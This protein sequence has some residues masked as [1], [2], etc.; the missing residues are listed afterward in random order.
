MMFAAGM[1]VMMYSCIMSFGQTGKDLAEAEQVMARRE[2]ARQEAALRKAMEPQLAESNRLAEIAAEREKAAEVLAK[3]KAEAEAAK[4]ELRDRSQVNAI[5]FLKK[6]VAEGSIS[7]TYK[8]GLR[9]LEGDGVEIDK[10][11][12]IRLLKLAAERGDKK[13][14]EKLQEFGRTPMN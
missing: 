13:A 9:Y 8:L 7:A 2:N 5:E 11:E 14:A 6:R 3:Q 10:A 4:K 12:A 1:C